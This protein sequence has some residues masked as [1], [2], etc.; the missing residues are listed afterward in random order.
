MVGRVYWQLKSDDPA[1]AELVALAEKVKDLSTSLAVEDLDDADYKVLASYIATIND[2]VHKAAALL[3]VDLSAKTDD[4]KTIL[5]SKVVERLTARRISAAKAAEE[6]GISRQFL[7]TVLTGKASVGPKVAET[8][9]AWLV[10]Y[11]VKK[12]RAVAPAT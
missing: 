8:L 11:P 2:T 12:K 6:M 3:G 10:K 5:I 9:N 1:V 7:S 4:A